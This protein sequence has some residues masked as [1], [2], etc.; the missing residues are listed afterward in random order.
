MTANRNRARRVSYSIDLQHSA[1]VSNIVVKSAAVVVENVTNLE[2]QLRR[3][4]TNPPLS[5]PVQR[6]RPRRRRSVSDIYKEL[7]SIYFRR[8]YRMTYASFKRLTALLCP[9][10]IAACGTKE[11]KGIAQTVPFHQMSDLPV[12]FDGSR[13]FYIWY[14]DYFWYQSNRDNQQLLVRCW[15]F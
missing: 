1:T 15:C 10:I 9:L 7:G 6:C 5:N 14:Y 4:M 8:A 13:G 3:H 12:H 11:L 2:Q